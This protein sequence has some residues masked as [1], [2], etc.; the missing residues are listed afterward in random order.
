MSSP[1]ID[2]GAATDFTPTIHRTP[3]PAIS[4]LL[5][6]LSQAGK[7]VLITGGGTGIGKATA[8]AFLRASAATIII[9]GRRLHKLT[10]AVSELEAAG[11]E[12]GKE[13]R[14][15][16][17]SCDVTDDEQVKGF[18]E[19]LERE[20]VYV[21]VLVLNS[22]IT[23]AA[24]SMFDIG[25]QAVWQVFEANVKGPLHFAELFY[26]QPGKDHAAQKVGTSH[27]PRTFPTN[28]EEM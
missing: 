4:P 25:V 23:T 24:A 5:P 6:S 21:D 18:W 3:Y 14:I 19:E 17:K 16:A 28:A 15:I 12:F 20:G 11:K 2:D 27:F 8:H 10:E 26:K 1:I 7:T 9:I 22:A 13:V